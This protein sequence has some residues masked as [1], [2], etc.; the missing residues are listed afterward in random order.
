MKKYGGLTPTP[1]LGRITRAEFS[2]FGIM[3]AKDTEKILIGMWAI[4]VPHG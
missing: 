1:G 2:G 3:S 4:E